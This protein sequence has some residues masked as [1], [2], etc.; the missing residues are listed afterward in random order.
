MHLTYKRKINGYNNKLYYGDLHSK[1]MDIMYFIIK[2]PSYKL[3]AR[4]ATLI[5]SY[6]ACH[7]MYGSQDKELMTRKYVYI[8]KFEFTNRSLDSRLKL[9]YSKCIDYNIQIDDID[10]IFVQLKVVDCKLPQYHYSYSNKF[11]RLEVFKII[12]NDLLGNYF[13]NKMISIKVSLQPIWDS[14]L[15]SLSA[16]CRRAGER[17]CKAHG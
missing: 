4:G 9:I 12:T 5:I 17:L 6:K 10:L 13:S 2:H 7:P 14:T 16:Y 11:S 8:G 15:A 1:V 3:K